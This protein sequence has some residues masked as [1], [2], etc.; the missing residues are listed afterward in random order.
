MRVIRSAKAM[1]RTAAGLTRRGKTIGLVPTMGALHE[2]HAS[3][4]RAA[5]AE[6]EVVIVTIFVNPLQFGPQE[7]FARY[8]RPLAR[9]LRI[10]KAAGAALVFVPVVSEIYPEGFSSSID[11]GPLGD[12]WEGKSRPGHFRGVATVVSILFHLTHPTCAYFGQKDYQQVQVLRR[13]VRDL[14]FPLQLRV[15]PTV[16]EPDGLAMS[17]RNVYLSPALRRE[18]T[19]L[20]RSL[21]LAK[22]QLRMGERRAARV[23]GAMRR[24]IRQQPDARIEYIA[25]VDA[26]TLAPLA[27]LQ[28]RVAVMLAVRFGATRLIDNIVVDVHNGLVGKLHQ[29]R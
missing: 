12:L 9:D 20:S 24:H 28:G 2:G 11:V 14:H 19:V 27:R 7:D 22:Q 23:L 6:N 16:R 5:A 8:P 17:S 3:L 26:E 21:A 18:A 1:E 10:A 13:M 29:G 25:A 15:L 4:I